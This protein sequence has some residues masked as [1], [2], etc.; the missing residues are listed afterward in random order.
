LPQSVKIALFVWNVGYNP[1]KEGRKMNDFKEYKK[2]GEPD[3]LKKLENWQI[4]IGL[5]QVDGLTPSKY[6]IKLAKDNIEGKIS[7]DEATK[8]ISQYYKKNPAKTAAAMGKQEADEVSSRIAKLLSNNTFVFSPA[9]LL[10][11]HKFLFKGILEPKIIGKIRKYDISKDEPVLN[12]DS[13]SYSSANSIKDT[14]DYDFKQE[15]SFNFKGLSKQERVEHIMKFMSG[16]WQIHPFGEGNTRTIAVFIIKYLRTLGFKVNNELFEEY[17]LYFRNALVRANY[18]N[19]EKSVYETSEY[20]RKFFGNL[21]LGERNRLNNAD[22]QV[23]AT[24]R[25]TTRKILSALQNN[26]SATRK[27]LAAV[28]GISEEG[29]KWN[30]NKLRKE[31][32]IIRVGGDRGGYW[33]VV[34]KE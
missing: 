27:E 18:N 33:K 17:S 6:L 32:L 22:M 19:F 14:L 7:I 11:I 13:V 21:L 20:L 25:K 5:Q 9:E 10:S 8:Q 28:I 4:A 31:G 23:D 24:T 1:A 30:L 29:I 16:I 26:L 3:K 15:K 34:E 2:L 12:G